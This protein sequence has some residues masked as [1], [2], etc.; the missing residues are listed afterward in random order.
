MA[1]VHKNRK[2]DVTDCTNMN[3]IVSLFGFLLAS[4]SKPPPRIDANIVCLQ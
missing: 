2:K 1:A 4:M 3:S